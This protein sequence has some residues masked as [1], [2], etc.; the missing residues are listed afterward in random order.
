MK[1]RWLLIVVLLLCGCNGEFN[2]DTMVC[3][4]KGKNVT[5]EIRYK[6]HD[7][8]RFSV[9]DSYDY[10]EF[11]DV[12]FKN[13]KKYYEEKAKELNQVDGLDM[14]I[15]IDGKAITAV[16]DVDYTKYDIYNDPNYVLDFEMKEEDF[17]NIESIRSIFISHHYICDEIVD[18]NAKKPVSENE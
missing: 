5:Y 13:R 1:K 11:S 8:K 15:T 6:D 17:K 3:G 16:V 4:L 18:P 9:I 7:I 10:E 14:T 12:Y 2:V